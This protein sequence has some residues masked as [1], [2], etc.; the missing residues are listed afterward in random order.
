MLYSSTLDLWRLYDESSSKESKSTAKGGTL[1]RSIK[2]TISGSAPL[3]MHSDRFANPI[4]PETIAHKKLTSKRTKTTEDYN[5]IA[6][7]E[8]MGGL[9]YH[10]DIGV[11]VPSN[12]IYAAI[13]GGGKLYKLGQHVKRSV[14]ILEPTGFAL[15][16]SGPKDPAAL[17]EK[18]AFVDSRAVKVGQAKLFRY[19][20]RFDEWS[21]NGALMLNESQLS[22]DDL[23][24]C[25]ESAGELVGM[26]DYRPMFGR[27]DVDL[28]F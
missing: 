21:V 25:F 2:F 1:N 7:S 6:R 18:T 8:W 10:R 3:L 19:R 14:V 27:F 13:V 23:Q 9:Y 15:K 28:E 17:Y 12:M 4:A 24:K 11:Y 20:P 16:Y 5:A 22:I 26:G